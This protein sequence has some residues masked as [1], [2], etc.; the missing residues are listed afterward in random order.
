MSEREF[1]I[2][3]V[4][5]LRDAGHQALWAGGCVRDELLGLE[6]DDYD[7]ASDARPEEVAHLFRR[8]IAVGASFGVV[9]V[10]G[11][12]EDPQIHVQVATLRSDGAY[13]DG[14]HPEAVRFSSAEED[15]QRRDF[16]INGLFFDPL[17]NRLID[18]VGGRAD[19]EAR[20]LRAI[21]DPHQ[22]FAEDK[23]RLMR[24][25]RMA[26]RFGLEIE[27]ATLDA[28]RTMADQITVVSAERIADELKKML[29]LPER[30][31]ALDLCMDLGLARAVLPELAL[32]PGLAENSWGQSNGDRWEHVLRALA[33][34][35]KEVSFPLALACLLH[36]VG[37]TGMTESASGGDTPDGLE[38]TASKLAGLVCRRLKL[39]VAERERVEWL[40]GHQQILRDAKRLPLHKLKRILAHTGIRE[41]LALH[42]AEALAE[43]LP[44][45]HVDFCEGL[46]EQWSEAEL[47]PPALITGH[48]V[49]ALGLRPGPGYKELLEV[50][51]DAQLDGMVATRDEAL[52]LLE[53]AVSGRA[54]EGR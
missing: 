32:Q 53:R 7:V 39:S 46:L 30:A 45:D 34:L 13:I 51:R 42:R 14:R 22:R 18:Y 20:L 4:R 5:R 52:A 33:C 6:P 3:V 41:L 28:I 19:L 49:E 25:V 50:V 44:T 54:K 12:R 8:T 17:E 23:L 36:E 27:P 38:K 2:A 35:G 11:P 48:D 16:T 29:L 43:E 24:G 37:K 15:A 47:N 10:L 1:A 40:V 26:A 9:E 21:G 31:R